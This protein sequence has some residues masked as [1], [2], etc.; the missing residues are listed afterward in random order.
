MQATGLISH[1]EPLPPPHSTVYNLEIKQVISQ[2]KYL[3]LIMVIQQNRM[4]PDTDLK[5]ER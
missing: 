1:M 5:S 4:M 2:E 3:T